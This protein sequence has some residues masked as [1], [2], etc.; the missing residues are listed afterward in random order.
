MNKYQTIFTEEDFKLLPREIRTEF[1]DFL[2]NV[3]F[4]NWLIQPEEIRGRAKDRIKHNEL[5]DTDERKQYNDGRI[6]VDVVKPHILEDIDFFRER[7]IFF[8]THKKYTNIPPNPNPKSDYAKFWKRELKRWKYGL[9]RPSDGEWIPGGLY[10]YWNYCPIWQTLET[11][12]DKGG[13]TRGERVYEFPKPW[14]GDYLFYHYMEQGREAGQHG[15]L[16]KT[17]GVGFEQPHS[18]KVKTFTGEKTVGEIKIGDKLIG[19]DGKETTVLEIYPQ[20]LKDVYEVELMDGRKIRC[21]KD[22]LWY[23]KNFTKKDKKKAQPVRLSEMMEKGLYWDI[24]GGNNKM[25]KYK[26]PKQAPV[27]YP[28]KELPIHPYI[29]GLLI[30]DGTLTT[31][32]IK[33]ATKDKFIIE[34]IERLLPEYSLTKDTTNCNY[35]FTSKNRFNATEEDLK[36]YKNSQYGLNKLKREIKFLGLNVKC[37]SKFI[38]EIYKMGSIEQRFALL[39]GLMDSDGSVNFKGNKEF[40][41]SNLTL[42]KDVSDVVRSLGMKCR[43][44]EGRPLREKEW[45]DRGTVTCQ[46]EYRLHIITNEVIFRLP[47]KAERCKVRKIFEDSAIINIK[48]LDY[49]EESSCFLVDND[50]HTYLTTDYTVTHNSFK[51]GSLSPRNMYVYPGSGNPNFHLASDKTFLSG[52]KGVFGKVIDTLDWI[53]TH[54]PLPKLRLT[55]SKKSME[56][57]LGYLDS[58]GVRQG[59]LSSVYGI[60]MKDNPDKARGIRGALIHYE[61]DGVFPDLESTWNINRKATED[62]NVAFSYQL[63]GGTGGSEGSNFIGSEKLF[64]NT[65]AYNIYGVSNVYDKNSTASSKCGFFWGAYLN[66]NK[67][68]DESTG[69][70]DVTKALM[71]IVINRAKTR[72]SASDSKTITQNI[73]EECLT[74][75]EAVMRV[76]GT[77]FPVADL[78]EWLGEISMDMSGFTSPHYVGEFIIDAS[79]NVQF[80][81]N[82]DVYPIR[83]FPAIDNK[84]G[85]VELF[86][87]PKNNKDPYRFVIAIDPY[88]DDVVEYSSSLGSCI[89]FDRWTRRIVGE[90]TGRPGSANEFYEICYRMARFYNGFIIYENNKKGLFTYFNNVKKAL[91]MLADTPEILVD[92][93]LTKAKSAGTNVSKGINATAAINSYALRLQA[94]WMLE[95]AYDEENKQLEEG[96]TKPFI[97]NLRKIRSIGYLKEAIAWHPKLNADRI[98]AFGLALIYDAELSQYYAGKLENRIQTRADDPFFKRVYKTS[99]PDAE[100]GLLEKITPMTSFGYKGMKKGLIS[101]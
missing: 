16:L 13:K 80:K 40:S 97:P 67:C 7:A 55:D 78:K 53:A 64:Y 24:N 9:I 28:E 18:E 94:D 45:P 44:S 65:D 29:L 37:F 89:V 4:I 17:R 73:A 76:D 36:K 100:T 57:Q 95:E 43:L 33:I 3:P 87:L 23:V 19:I 52:D 30:G 58:Y 12:V 2:E 51:L 8:N 46:Q 22:H 48:K 14:L 32:N 96:E 82:T 88:D 68:Y 56:I 62:G 41:S 27:D 91:T 93:Q 50:T 90:Y 10:F 5:P 34:E 66:R 21:G 92:K 60:S 70:P 38:P 84:Q 59:I 6:V 63:A 85:A 25:Y 101:N 54:T 49:Q 72:V 31:R 75:Q 71:E 20:G 61:E 35:L 1:Y 69:E 77:I 26:I 86:E 83:E 98:S 99:R 42:I 74:P 39:Q 81:H 79:G 47:R 11:G 15:K